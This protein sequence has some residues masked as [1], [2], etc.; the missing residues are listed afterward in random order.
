MA[1]PW[2]RT[3]AGSEALSCFVRRRGPRGLSGTCDGPS[4]RRRLTA[5]RGR[6]VSPAF[7]AGRVAELQASRM[8]RRSAGLRGV[9]RCSVGCASRRPDA[10]PSGP[11]LGPFA[12]VLFRGGLDLHGYPAALQFVR[13]VQDPPSVRAAALP[14]VP[15]SAGRSTRASLL[16][17][18]RTLP[19]SGLPP[20]PPSLARPG[21]P[22]GPASFR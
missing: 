22:L 16:Q 17:I 5:S 7:S 15:R 4:T 13:R 2:G 14:P 6:G 18:S 9:E 10:R 8:A 19:L 12:Q 21:R 1:W 20:F 3:L 11:V